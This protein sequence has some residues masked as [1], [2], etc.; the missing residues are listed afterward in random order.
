MKQNPKY[1]S[2]IRKRQNGT[3]NKKKKREKAVNDQNTKENLSLGIKV[4]FYV[5]TAIKIYYIKTR[6]LPLIGLQQ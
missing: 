1:K 4:T 3:R 5:Q 2:K 6:T